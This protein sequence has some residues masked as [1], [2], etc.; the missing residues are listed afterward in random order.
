MKPNPHATWGGAGPVMGWAR[1]GWRKDR[2]GWQ[3]VRYVRGLS[4]GDA[5]AADYVTAGAEFLGGVWLLASE[6]DAHER[7]AW[8]TAYAARRAA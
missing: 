5:R 3:D 8:P 6:A 1:F 2:V 7:A 4:E